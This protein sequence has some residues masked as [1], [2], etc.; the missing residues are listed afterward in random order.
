MYMHSKDVLIDHHRF[1]MNVTTTP[2]LGLN[3]TNPSHIRPGPWFLSPHTE[4]VSAAGEA[5]YDCLTVT[6]IRLTAQYS[7]HGCPPNETTSCLL[8]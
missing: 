8:P 5:W 3:L 1:K 2:N 7:P 4:A 6:R